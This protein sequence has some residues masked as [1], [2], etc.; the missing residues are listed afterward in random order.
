MN[1]SRHE[2]ENFAWRRLG[3]FHSALTGSTQNYIWCQLGWRRPYKHLY[4]ST[5]CGFCSVNEVLFS[6]WFVQLNRVKIS[7]L[8]ALMPWEILSFEQYRFSWINP[9]LKTESFLRAVPLFIKINVYTS[10]IPLS[11]SSLFL[12]DIISISFLSIVYILLEKSVY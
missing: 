8:C 4:T 5:S 9:L 2:M 7:S 6:P 3:A 1:R 12:D 10:T 11:M